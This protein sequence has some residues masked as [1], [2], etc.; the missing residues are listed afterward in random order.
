MAVR[1]T[2][3]ALIS[4]VRQLI[5]DPA[6][7]G[8]TWA[9]QDIQDVLDASRIDIFNGSMRAQPTFTGSSLLY[10]DFF[11]DLAGWEDDF[12][13][14]QYLVNVVTP[15]TSEPIVGHWTFALT[16]LPPVYITGKSYDVWRA[17]ADLLE[18]TA[19][20]WALSYDFSSDGQS[21]RRS[22]VLPA[23][24]SLAHTYRLKQRAGVLTLSRS[25]VNGEGTK[26]HLGPTAI[27]YMGSGDGR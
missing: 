3:A 7:V 25:D 21:F 15:A 19:A 6:G 20:K 22:Q 9:D 1:S 18:R 16:T 11:T 2:M 8:Q 26:P 23:L 10:L 24:Q 17:A 27:D 5:N 4:R 12:V 13:L 14:K